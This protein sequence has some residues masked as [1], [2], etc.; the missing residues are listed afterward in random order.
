MKRNTPLQRRQPEQQRQQIQQ[1]QG[2]HERQGQEAVSR[3]R[4]LSNGVDVRRRGRGT[5]RR[6]SVRSMPTQSHFYFSSSSSSLSLSSSSSS[7][8]TSER[9]RCCRCHRCRYYSRFEMTPEN[10]RPL[11]ENAKEVYGRLRA[12]IMEIR[13]LLVVVGRW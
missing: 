8:M 13:G 6:G 7:S 11:V 10:I 4:Y 1:R 3:A 2:Q 5:R 12:C 9:H